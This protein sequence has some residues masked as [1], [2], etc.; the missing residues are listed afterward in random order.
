MPRADLPLSLLLRALPDLPDFAVLRRAFLAASAVDPRA[1]WAGSRS[2]AT[3]EQRVLPI[4]EL[5]A[6]LR[7]SYRDGMRRLTRIHRA[8]ERAFQHVADDRGDDAVRELVTLGEAAERGDQ[9]QDAVAFYQLAIDLCAARARLRAGQMIEAEAFYRASFGH[10]EA[11][12][13]RAGQVVALTGL[14]NIASLQGRWEIAATHYQ[15]ALQRTTPAHTQLRGQIH[16]NLSMTARE[17]REHPQAHNHLD[18]ARSFWDDLTADDR[19]VWFNNLGLLHIALNQLDDAETALA[20][21]L[22]QAPGHFDCAMIFDNFA[23]IATLR[24]QWARA[25]LYARRAEEHALT[26]GSQRALADAY[27]RLGGLHRARRD[28]NAVG[29]FEQAVEIARRGPFPVVEAR[30]HHEYG[31]FRRDLGDLDDARGEFQRAIT[32]FAEI[33][34]HAAATAA[35]AD[36]ATLENLAT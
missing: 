28:A 34:A 8:L 7:S 14:G 1:E 30:A 25:E 15:N 27:L 33:G 21:A 6:A 20:D 18:Q 19:A 31:L 4:G 23:E 35:R 12:D 5:T 9:W 10:A 32:L 2:Y 17:R 11:H 3:F 36:L 16:I 24:G 13:D 29:F 22:E 26:V